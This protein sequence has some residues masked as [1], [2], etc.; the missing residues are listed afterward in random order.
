MTLLVDTVKEY[1]EASN[2]LADYEYL[3]L[4]DE[5]DYKNSFIFVIRQLP[6]ASDD[7]HSLDADFEVSFITTHN[8]QPNKVTQV[9]TDATNLRKYIFENFEYDC[10]INTSILSEPSGPFHTESGRSVYRFNFR[11]ETNPEL[12]Y[13]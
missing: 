10:I 13:G 9:L 6:T 12:I 5:S 2:I 7:I 11:V 3:Y 1:L 8:K 4:F